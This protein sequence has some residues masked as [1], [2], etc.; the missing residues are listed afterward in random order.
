M[1]P[2]NVVD[3]LDSQNI[4]F[5][6][7]RDYANARYDYILD[8]MRLKEQAGLL[9]PDDV[10]KLDENLIAPPS[11]TASRQTKSPYPTAQ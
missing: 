1:G 10:Y 3:V 8:V 7:K 5:A 2:R 6:A 9:S 4:L 11:P